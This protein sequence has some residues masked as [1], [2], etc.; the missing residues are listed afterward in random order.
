MRAENNYQFPEF[1]IN[2]G[3]IH[4]QIAVWNKMGKE[5]KDCC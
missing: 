5:Y 4:M 3:G 1:K 2:G